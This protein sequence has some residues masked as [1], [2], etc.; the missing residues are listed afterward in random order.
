MEE[1]NF[2]ELEEAKEKRNFVRAA[3]IAEDL[4]MSPE[5]VKKLQLQAIKQFIVE[6]R[7]PQGAITLLK[8]YQL[9][10]EELNH[11]LQEILREL[12]ERGDNERR[13]FD[14]QT[15]DYLTLEKWID[16]YLKKVNNFIKL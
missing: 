11:F 9:N 5:E 13:Q 15:M 8:E 16:Q 3:K 2:K 10:R 4:G 14:I 1:K 6:Y 12:K 7:N